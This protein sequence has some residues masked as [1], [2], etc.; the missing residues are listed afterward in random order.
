MSINYVQLLPQH[1]DAV[2]A[3]G[4]KVHGDNYL[5]ENSLTDLYQRSWSDNINAS[6]VAVRSPDEVDQHNVTSVRNTPD[7]YLI[8]FRLTTAVSQW[9]PDKWCSPLL[10]GI[11]K[12]KICYFKCNTVDTEMRGLGIGSTLLKKSIVTSKQQG[13]LA[14]VAHIWLASPG[15]SAFSYFKACG[16]ELVKEHANRWQQYSIEDS[17]DCPVCGVLCQ[18]TAAEMILR[19][20]ELGD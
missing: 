5:D 3:L 9:L 17:Y 14:G 8:G 1:F 11:P 4:N 12:E 16:G 13:A 19:F 7:G 20:N 6:W 10:W 18:C 2:I 15:N